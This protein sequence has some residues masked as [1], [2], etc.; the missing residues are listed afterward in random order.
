MR[1]LGELRPTNPAQLDF[2]HQKKSCQKKATNLP[3][4]SPLTLPQVEQHFR[5]VVGLLEGGGEHAVL[6]ERD[7][8]DAGRPD[9]PVHRLPLHRAQPGRARLRLLCQQNGGEGIRT[10]KSEAD[11]RIGSGRDR[12]DN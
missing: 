7:G 1:A 8:P 12:L 2:N 4:P 3:L 11:Q 9:E 6:G 5:G 10:S